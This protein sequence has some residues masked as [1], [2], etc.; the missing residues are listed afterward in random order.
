MVGFRDERLLIF[1]GACGSNLQARPL[2]DRAWGERCSG[3]NEYLNLSAPEAVVDLHRSF[4]E[5]GAMVVETNTFGGTGIVLAE[6][7]LEDRAAA[8]NEAAV[9][10]ARAAID[11]ASGR[12]VAGSM[13]PGTKLPSL[14][15]IPH[16]AVHDAFFAQ[17]AA[18]AGAG[19][20]A[21]VIETCQ[22]LF[23]AK[24]ALIAS[25]EALEKAGID[26]PV[27]LSVTMETT[28][29]MLVG[30]DI[31]AVVATFEP[32]EL[33]SLGLNCATGPV[34]MAPHVDY[35]SR[36]WPGRISVIPNAGMPEVRDGVTLYPLGP[37]ELAATLR[38]F[39]EE[40]GVSVVG[41]C[42][43]T[44][45]AHIRALSEAL[46]A[47]APGPRT[48]AYPPSLSSLYGAVE[49]RQQI[50]PLMIGER[51]NTHGSRGFKK[52]LLAGDLEG[53][54][55]IGPEQERGGAHLLDLCA[56]F[57]G[58]DEREDVVSLI[59]ILRVTARAPLVIDS[60]RPQIIEA[61][62][63]A[64][65][66]RCLINS[67]NLEDGGATA[68]QVLRLARKHG[69]AVIALTI[70]PD[71]MA[72][73]AA[74]KARIAGDLYALAVEEHG[75]RPS[76]LFFDALTFTIGSG[77]P[78]LERSAVETLEAI[79]LIKARLPGVLTSLGVSNVSFGLPQHSRRY[80]NS[81][82][83]AQAIEAGLDAAIVDAAKIVPVARIP[84]ED[85]E[86]CLDL[87]LDRRRSGAAAPLAAYLAHFESAAGSADRTES[88]VTRPEEA[89]EARILDGDPSDLADLLD[90][91]RA[92][93]APAE[94]INGLLVPAMR[95]VGALFGRGEML[96]PF[97]LQSAQV[98]KAAVK[99][100]E[101]HMDRAGVEDG[102][103][104]LLATVQGDVHDIGKNLVDII[105]SN[106]GYRV[107]D[108]GTNV[109]ASRLIELARAH[110]VDAIGLSG[111]LVRS[112]LEMRDS[113]PRF[114]EAGLDVPILLGGAALTSRFV[115]E[116]CVPSHSRPVVYCADA[117]AGLEAVRELEQ[118][119]LRPTIHAT[120][121]PMEEPAGGA[122]IAID[123]ANPVPAPPFL[124][125][126]YR[127]EIDI[128]LL[129]DRLNLEALF[130]ARWGYKRGKLS[131]AE[132][133][134]LIDGAAR[135]ALE[136]LTGR[137]RGE[138][139]ISAS[140]AYGYFRC[141]SSGD[142]LIVEGDG[143]EVIL[144]FPRQRHE[145]RLCIADYFKTAG[146]G[147]DVVGLFVA[148]VGDRVTE[149]ARRLFESDRYRDYLHL[150]GFAVEMAEAL[151]EHWH[152][153][154]RKELGIAGGAC[155]VAAPGCCGRGN[156]YGVGYSSCPDLDA[157][158]QIFALL[159]PA[160]IG[161]S[162]TET[163]QIVPEASTS[164]IIVHHP[165][166][167]YFNV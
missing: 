122:S 66:G 145:P 108:A 132:H 96:L 14:G 83:L 87:L 65:P 27:L 37:E 152:D 163:A 57:A 47:V 135:P 146:G 134:A 67:I 143:R 106:N 151:A 34:H 77:D 117:F 161:V 75:L 10:N 31:A 55:A 100:L 84:S 127:R 124:G 53:A 139:L 138:G 112:A 97:V 25:L 130:R 63:E 91:L 24:V 26:I 104:V 126:R 42:C 43:G 80:L 89:I 49:A 52:L 81:V 79:R 20:D 2:P 17:A 142:R 147:G 115:A 44:T 123:R 36:H 6:Y 94:I 129:L 38:R 71:G 105:L 59:E 68:R 158:R 95:K 116:E 137:C 153:E 103:K 111:L 156:R 149:E 76:D 64:Y 148:T 51:M 9:R 21:L 30:S 12:Y 113:I 23:Q 16:R 74:D 72:M 128:D 33:F 28:G 140:V 88:P 118:G 90:I 86:I 102:T 120:A 22:D 29:T 167:E 110:A 121:A 50:P 93:R 162:L 109:P 92:R 62:L 32:F 56:A 15:H 101:P 166:A 114:R 160:A 13:G 18:L 131:Q 35:L 7:G 40:R 3:C 48:P 19:A 69:A 61:A 82:F 144:E 165:Q 164:A 98:M 70:G 133:A 157:Q 141:A 39:V 5:A 11:G 150:H 155:D 107:I 78:T 119:R 159:D 8:I 46:R 1:D 73:T 136:A 60:T 45:P 99:H 54:A 4:L 41:G 154:M 85:L 58:R 125:V